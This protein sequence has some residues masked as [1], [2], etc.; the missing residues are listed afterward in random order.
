MLANGEALKT[1]E[2]TEFGPTLELAKS[3]S[4]AH[5]SVIK[6]RIEGS[7]QVNVVPVIAGKDGVIRLTPI[8]ATLNGGQKIG[9]R[10]GNPQIDHWTNPK[11]TLSWNLQATEYG[12]YLLKMHTAVEKEAVRMNIQ[13]LGQMT[14]SI[15]KTQN[16]GTFESV[17][18]GEVKLKK[19]ETHKLVLQPAI[20]AWHPVTIRG[21]ELV[22]VD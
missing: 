14:C 10:R 5:C 9:V 3:G 12:T 16:L 18:V 6:V 19:G 21:L 1:G 13:G 17:E 4:D 22:P 2:V 15:P 11:D 20:D 8:A 7:P